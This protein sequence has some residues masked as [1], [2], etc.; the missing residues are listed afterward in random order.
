[1]AWIPFRRWLTPTP[2]E[3]DYFR[4]LM[5]QYEGQRFWERQ[6]L[7]AR[8]DTLKAKPKPTREDIC[9]LELITIR[10]QSDELV[11]LSLPLLRAKFLEAVGQPPPSAPAGTDI[12]PASIKEEAMYLTGEIH[13]SHVLNRYFEYRRGRMVQLMILVAL[14]L[15]ALWPAVSHVT[16]IEGAPGIML[17]AGI[18]GGVTSS[19]Q[20]VYT[21]N[22]AAD[23]VASIQ[24][25]AASTTSILAAPFLGAIFAIVFWFLVL[26][27]LVG[28]D[29]FPKLTISGAGADGKSILFRDFL[30]GKTEAGVSDYAKLILWGFLAGFAERLI[31]D[32]LNS[33]S[34][35][36]RFT[37]K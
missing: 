8:I 34:A 36:A 22:R 33:I 14:I 17:V 18:F 13:R 29:A 6:E 5:A 16:G 4:T 25:L 27:K 2:Y 7:L 12:A 1:M 35:K 19:L 32:V 10:T 20:R 21:M 24:S 11:R 15:V 37:N 31:P 23:V 9:E 3:P 30:Y 28:G 26:G